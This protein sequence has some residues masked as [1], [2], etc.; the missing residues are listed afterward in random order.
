MKDISAQI[1][2]IE[3]ELRE[4]PYHKGTEHHLGRLKAKLAK[5]QEKQGQLTK[6]KGGYGFIP[7]KEGDATVVLVGPPSVGKSTLLNKLTRAHARVEPWP[8]TTL[9][10]I[11]GMLDYQGAKIQIFD[12]PG[13]LGG[14]A[15]GVARG[16]E[17]LSATRAVD[18]LI[19]MVDVGT[20]SQIPTL[21]GE[22]NEVGINL[23]ILVVVNKIDLVGK[24]FLKFPPGALLVSVQAGEGLDELKEK[25]WGK[26]GLIRIY[27]KPKWR[28]PDFEK[29]LILRKG[30]TVADVAARIFPGK[31]DFRKIVVWGS[32]TRFPG[33]PVS[34]SHQLKDEDILSF[35]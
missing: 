19:L 10:V 15:K 32:S 1:A 25:I 9:K 31:T 11:P 6:R 3:Q 29:P 26:L 23:P 21:L 35:S 34:L 16:K 33:Q 22:L 30:Q 2:Q 20:Y 28:K 17:V 12:L 24:R 18:L 4:T 14:A 27:L 13:I 5:L 8:F 7:K